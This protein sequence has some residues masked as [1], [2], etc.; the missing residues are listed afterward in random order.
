[1]CSGKRIA[2]NDKGTEIINPAVTPNWSCLVSFNQ[3]F[4]SYIQILHIQILLI[5]LLCRVH[6]ETLYEN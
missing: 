4:W 2:W 6:I 1:M 3:L 5:I